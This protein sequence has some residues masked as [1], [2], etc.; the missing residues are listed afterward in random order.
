M[1]P[2]AADFQP[3][4]AAVSVNKPRST[5]ELFINEHTLHLRPEESRAQ[6]LQAA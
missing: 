3:L 4:R 2:T 6:R 1:V 5:A